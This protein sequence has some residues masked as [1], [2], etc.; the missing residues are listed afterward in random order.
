MRSHRGAALLA[1]SV[2]VA[3]FVALQAGVGAPACDL[4]TGRGANPA[5]DALMIVLA[6]AVIVKLA[7]LA[8]RF[9]LMLTRGR[10]TGPKTDLA[11]PKTKVARRIRQA[12]DFSGDGSQDDVLIN[13]S[14]GTH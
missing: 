1:I 9:G 13:R 14:R 3:A 8:R 12:G 7:F 11:K 10:A 5:A 2:R 4:L 6:L